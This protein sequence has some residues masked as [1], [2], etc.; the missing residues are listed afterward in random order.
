MLRPVK[1]AADEQARPVTRRRA[2]T[3]EVRWRFAVTH[4]FSAEVLFLIAN[5]WIQF[6][7]CVDNLDVFV[8]LLSQNDHG[9][10][11]RLTVALVTLLYMFSIALLLSVI[12]F[13]QVRLSACTRDMRMRTLLRR[14]TNSL[15]LLLQTTLSLCVAGE[16]VLY[17]SRGIHFAGSQGLNLG[18]FLLTGGDLRFVLQ[19]VDAD[20]RFLWSSAACWVLILALQTLHWQCWRQLQFRYR[21]VEDTLLTRLMTV[22][23]VV[24]SVSTVI[25]LLFTPSIPLFV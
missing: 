19:V 24:L 14:C 4:G 5:C 20:M 13:I 7:F 25:L 16:V 15:L 9:A 3:P 11:A 23:H 17:R 18:W 2:V 21:L 6:L 12:K 10:L 1:G 8:M 22:T